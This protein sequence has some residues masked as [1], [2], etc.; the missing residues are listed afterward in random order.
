MN[1]R[2][3]LARVVPFAAILLCLLCLVYASCTDED[4][5]LEPLPDPTH[6][7]GNILAGTVRAVDAGVPGATDAEGSFCLES[8]PA[9][10]YDAVFRPAVGEPAP[11]R[12]VVFDVRGRA[13][14]GWHGQ[15]AEAEERFVEWDLLDRRG[16]PVPPGFYFVR[17][18]S[19]NDVVVRSVVV[20]GD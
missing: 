18:E 3:G 16:Q 6:E 4:P 9:D 5:T 10:T 1:E 7:A 19:G 2:N 15:V 17:A 14:R 8:V 13:V 12:L 11:V 20:L